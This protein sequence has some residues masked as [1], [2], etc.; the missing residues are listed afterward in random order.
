[1]GRRITIDSATMMNKGFRGDRSLLALRFT[2]LQMEVVVHPQSSIHAMVEY[3]DGSL[4]AQISATDMRMP[5]QYALTYPARLQ[6]PVPRLDW[7]K[8]RTWD[9]S[10]P[11]LEKFRLLEAGV[12]GTTTR[13]AQLPVR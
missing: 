12:R 5:I 13:A 8:P 11:D 9:F 1:M 3:T 10:A 2:D 6:A 7:T 4:I